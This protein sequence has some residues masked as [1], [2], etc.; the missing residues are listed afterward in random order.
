[1]L[2]FFQCNSLSILEQHRSFLFSSPHRAHLRMLVHLEAN[3]RA[4]HC[5]AALLVN[6]SLEVLAL[7]R[8]F[9]GWCRPCKVGY[10]SG[11]S[12]IQEASVWKP[13]SGAFDLLLTC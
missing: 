2:S 3:T 10:L 6:L 11:T 8:K 13:V 7:L 4:G 12:L 5:A 1:M 9:P